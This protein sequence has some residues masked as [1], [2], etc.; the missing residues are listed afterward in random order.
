MAFYG[1]VFGVFPFSGEL[2]TYYFKSNRLFAISTRVNFCSAKNGDVTA[3]VLFL[4][5]RHRVF[6]WSSW[7]VFKD[8]VNYSAAAYS[9][10]SNGKDYVSGSPATLFFGGKGRFAG[11]SRQYVRINFRCLMPWIIASFA[12]QCRL[13]G[14]TYVVRR[15]IRASVF[16][17]DDVRRFLGI[18]FFNCV[19][20]CTC[21]VVSLLKR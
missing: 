8:C 12:R 19:H 10:G 2:I 14:G 21:C 13:I 17:W 6:N 9:D 15:C 20:F 3:S 7:D 16:K 4:V 1:L 11:A 18:N 5:I